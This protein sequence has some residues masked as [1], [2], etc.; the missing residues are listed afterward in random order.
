MKWNLM[1]FLMLLSINFLATGQ[2]VQTDNGIV[3]IDTQETLN[4]QLEQF[5]GKVVYID[6]WATF[7]SPCIKLFKYKKDYDDYFAKNDIVVLCLCIDNAKRK[8]TWKKLINENSVTG[9]HVFVE[10]DLISEYTTDLKASKKCKKTLGQ[11]FPRFLI[12]DRDGFVV[13]D[14]ALPPSDKLVD[15]MKKY[16]N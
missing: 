4:E 7:C 3:F 2:T 6:T 5:K 11:G 15:N 13:E 10:Y 9:Y 1:T 8:E 16:L 14:R 12:V